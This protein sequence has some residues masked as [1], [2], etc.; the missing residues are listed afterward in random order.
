MRKL[1]AF[2]SG[3]R[4]DLYH[5]ENVIES[6]RTFVL[7]PS[8]GLSLFSIVSVLRRLVGF[9]EILSTEKAP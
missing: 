5:L 4:A 9:P 2:F 8:I 3:D 1:I 7:I 6:F